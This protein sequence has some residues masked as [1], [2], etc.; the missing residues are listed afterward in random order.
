MESV[1]KDLRST[2]TISFRPATVRTAFG[3]GNLPNRCEKYWRLIPSEVCNVDNID[4][5]RNELKKG[6]F[7]I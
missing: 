3:D 7:F 2:D 1:V 4:N 6:D 5:F